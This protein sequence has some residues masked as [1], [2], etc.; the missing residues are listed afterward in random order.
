MKT[1]KF[2]FHLKSGK[3]F[4]SIN[5]MSEEQYINAVALCKRGMN[6][7][8]GSLVLDD[9]CVQLSECAVVEWEVLD[10]QETEESE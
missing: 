9:C 7:G 10:E 4:D 6:E 5:S 2:R 8:R 3:Y 1:V